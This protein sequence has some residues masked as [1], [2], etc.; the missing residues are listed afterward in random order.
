MDFAA[1]F[2]F[3]RELLTRWNLGPGKDIS[4]GLATEGTENLEAKNMV[5]NTS[6]YKLPVGIKHKEQLQTSPGSSNS[7][8]SA[9]KSEESKGAQPRDISNLSQDAVDEEYSEID[10]DVYNSNLSLIE[11]NY[12][13]APKRKGVLSTRAASML[14]NILF[15]VTNLLIITKC[16]NTTKP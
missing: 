7:R 3:K 2:V 12:A 16:N 11:R 4:E 15:L 13:S 14:V 1:P 10:A 9:R 8:N 6:T 5:D